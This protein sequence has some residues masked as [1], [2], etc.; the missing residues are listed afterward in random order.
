MAPCL[1]HNAVVPV[2]IKSPFKM[3][4]SHLHVVPHLLVVVLEL[5]SCTSGRMGWPVIW[6]ILWSIFVHVLSLIGWTCS[7]LFVTTLLNWTIGDFSTY[8]FFWALLPWFSFSMF[9]SEVLT[10][11]C[12]GVCH[13]LLQL[14]LS[15]I[16]SSSISANCSELVPVMFL[17]D[18]L[19][20]N[21]TSTRNERRWVVFYRPTETCR[22]VFR[23]LP[24][25]FGPATYF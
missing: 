20:F 8:S 7:V 24:S 21:R 23:C 18:L 19:H 1:V 3:V 15:F 5:I 14:M 17:L 2:S 9:T 4:L 25:A 13:Y 6:P 10:S 22:S 16:Y 11:I 12:L